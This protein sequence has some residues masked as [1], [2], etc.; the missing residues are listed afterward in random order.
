MEDNDVIVWQKSNLPSLLLLTSAISTQAA[1]DASAPSDTLAAT[2][3]F[4]QISLIDSSALSNHWPIGLISFIS[5]GLISLG[6]ISLV[7]LS[8]FGLLSL[9]GISGL[10]GQIGV[11]FIGGFI[12]FVDLGLVSLARLIDGI[13]LIGLGGHNGIISLIGLSG[14][15]LVGLS[16]FG[17]VGL[18]GINGLIGHDCIISFI[19][20]FMDLGLA[21]L[22]NNISLT[23][24]SGHNG[25]VDFMGLGLIGLIGLGRVSLIG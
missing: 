16:G 11:S 4:G 3:S 15:G 20:G 24:P 9:S 2:A 8:G 14:F 22:I 13:G 1:L 23:G 17:L 12:G 6:L 25:L 18:S 5:L 19:L 10:V 7:G 21:G